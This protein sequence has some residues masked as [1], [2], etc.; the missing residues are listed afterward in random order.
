M[1]SFSPS[2]LGNK[3]IEVEMNWISDDHW[4]IAN[5]CKIFVGNP[6]KSAMGTKVYR[7]TI[8]FAYM[9]WIQLE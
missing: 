9:D 8:Y 2:Y 4:E 3:F 5:A 1:L 7:N 6:S